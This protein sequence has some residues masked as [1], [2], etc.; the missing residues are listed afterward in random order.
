MR[1]AGAL[2]GV[3][4]I[5]LY[6]V[7][8]AL[9]M[10][11]W[12]VTAASGLPLDATIRTMDSA[13]QFCGAAAGVLFATLGGTLALGWGFVALLPRFRVS[14]WAALALWSGIIACGAPAFFFASF[15]NM[16]SV[17]DTFF[18]WN[19]E[20]AF[21]LETPLYFASGLAALLAVAASVIAVVRT[22]RRSAILTP[23]LSTTQ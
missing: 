10:N 1:I 6:S 7:F 3:S 17:G 12:A 2:L 23:K 15:G 18:E 14:G 5:V 9:L 22:M 20:A 8:G 13:G 21:A 4:L 19:A 11:D 16:N